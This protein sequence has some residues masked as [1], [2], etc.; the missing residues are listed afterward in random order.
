MTDETPPL[1]PCA[2]CHHPSVHDPD[3]GCLYLAEYCP[4]AV[5]VPPSPRVVSSPS[6]A[7]ARVERDAAMAQVEQG[8]DT[9][10]V[11]IAEGAVAGLA[12]L[13]QPFTTDDVWQRLADRK[14]PSPR[15]P[16]ALGPV[17]K[18]AV[19][20]GIVEWTGGYTASTRRHTAPVRVYVRNHA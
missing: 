18:R 14:V 3:A 11:A 10:W 13:G 5:Y 16:R 9:W 19:R 17:M 8:S 12:S 1:P 2:D 6:L 20:D 7:R 4:C 15:E